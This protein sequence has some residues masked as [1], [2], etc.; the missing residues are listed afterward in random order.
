MSPFLCSA[1]RWQSLDGGLCPF[2]LSG[3]LERSVT[4]RYSPQACSEP[5]PH[6]WLQLFPWGALGELQ[7]TVS[8]SGPAGARARKSLCSVLLP[9]TLSTPPVPRQV[10]VSLQDRAVKIA[11]G[12]P[13]G[14]SGQFPTHGCGRASRLW[15]LGPGVPSGTQGLLGGCGGKVRPP[16]G[17]GR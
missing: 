11:P 4:F 14:G 6:I 12:R 10:C 2:A 16:H 13:R 3:V 7:A 17:P 15:G 8:P 9:H 1:G 5:P